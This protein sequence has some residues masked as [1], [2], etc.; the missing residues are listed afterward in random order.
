[1]YIVLLELY[2]ACRRRPV[3]FL[4]YL[5]KRQGTCNQIKIYFINIFSLILFLS[6]TSVKLYNDYPI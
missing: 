2:G 4:F 3:T 1:M 6:V 5:T